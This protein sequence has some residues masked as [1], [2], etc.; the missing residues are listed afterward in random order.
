MHKFLCRTLASLLCVLMLVSLL[1]AAAWAEEAEEPISA[2]PDETVAEYETGIEQTDEETPSDEA[3]TDPWEETGESTEGDSAAPDDGAPL[4]EST[5]SEDAAETGEDVG[6]AD[7]NSDA[8][9]STEAEKTEREEAEAEEAE[10]EETGTDETMAEDA[11]TEEIEDENRF[12]ALADGAANAAA[13]GMT[14]FNVADRISWSSYEF[15]RVSDNS[16]AAGSSIYGVPDKG[17]TM[18]IFFSTTCGNCMNEFRGISKTSWIQNDSVR[19]IAMETNGATQESTE[20]FLSDYAGA[21]R[22]YIEAYYGNSCPSL[23]WAYYGSLFDDST[24]YWPLMVLISEE[25]GI[26]MIRFASCGY[27]EPSEVNAR[28]ESLLANTADD[29]AVGLG[30]ASRT[31][32]EI[33]AFA[34]AHPFD[35]KAP[36]YR[37]EPSLSEPYSAGV[38]SDETLQSALNTLNLVRYIAGLSANVVLNERYNELCSAATLVNF[39]NQELSHYPSRPDV[40]SDAAYDELYE[41]GAKGASSSNLASGFYSLWE[42]VVK[43]WMNDGDSSNIDRV[44][45]RRWVLS[46]SMA[47]IGFGMTEDYAGMYAFGG[48]GSSSAYNVAWPAQYMP[49]QMFDASYPWSLS[50]GTTLTAA[51]TSVTLTRL[52]DGTQWHFS[53]TDSSGGVF[54]VNNGGYGL[55]GCVIFRPATLSRIDVGDVFVVQIDTVQ[56]GEPVRIRYNV[57]FFSLDVF[58]ECNYHQYV[59]VPG[60]EPTC[61]E[62]GITSYERCTICGY[63]SGRYDLDP[64]GH[65]YNWDWEW[66]EDCTA[67]DLHATCDRCGEEVFVPA[68]VESFSTPATCTEDGGTLHRARA[69]LDGEE[70]VGEYLTDYIPAFGHDYELTEWVWSEDHHS[71]DAVF[72]CRNDP[73]HTTTQYAQRISITTTQPTPTQRGKTIYTATLTFDGETYTDTVETD[74]PITGSGYSLEYTGLYI[75]PYSSTDIS[76]YSQLTGETVSATWYSDNTDVVTVDNDGTIHSQKSGVTQIHAKVGDSE[77]LTCDVTVMFTDVTEYNSYFFKPVYW[78]LEAGI[79]NG[80]STGEYAGKF[81]VGLPCTR[82]QMMTFLWRMAGQPNPKT[83]RNPFPDVPSNAYYYKAVLWGVENGITNGFSSGEY[84]GKFGVGLPCT[85]E[86]AMTFLWRMA[87]KPE[88]KTGSNPFADVKS[89]DYYYKAVLWASQNGIANGYSSG[90]YAGKYGVGLACLREHMVTFLYRYDSKF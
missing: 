19:V 9:S 54:Y 74:T 27:Q 14:E 73:S 59:S 7:G 25:D 76:V 71:A 61:T 4:P 24:L 78:A 72:V 68:E 26:P 36:T 1:P 55:R 33:Q 63:I 70:Y 38:L 79:T 45:H 65:D 17:V 66:S 88:P 20:A 49:L 37:V 21:A 48:S 57:T 44:G 22:P 39:L 30:V 5:E 60:V 8:E 16:L 18:L 3:A 84:A 46:P 10:P 64:L 58:S 32:A 75:S 35:G 50:T 41:D 43:G 40:L 67:A 23:M 34:D 42:A 86:Q 52:S 11:E 12:V 29:P 77:P 81:G 15:T 47:Q 56:N 13:A 80:Y 62:P 83:T 89:S 51:D 2:H 53:S 6:A 87:G 31:P 82:E 85:R 69:E 90:E 28:V